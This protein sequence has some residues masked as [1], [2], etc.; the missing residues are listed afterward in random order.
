MYVT[1]SPQDVTGSVT[2]VGV[3]NVGVLRGEV[4][5]EDAQKESYR[6]R[7]WRRMEIEEREDNR[8]L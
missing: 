1:V 3:R 5:R 6:E 8:R 4:K 2:G 7:L